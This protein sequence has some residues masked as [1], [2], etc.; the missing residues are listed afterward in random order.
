MPMEPL[1]PEPRDPVADPMAEH[2]QEFARRR[3]RTR[4]LVAGAILLPLLLALALLP[5]IASLPPVRARLLAQ[6]NARL[7]PRLLAVESWRLRWWGPLVFRGVRVTDATVGWEAAA[8]EVTVSRGLLR[9]LPI[10]RLDLGEV[11]VQSPQIALRLPDLTREAGAT[12]AAEPPPPSGK[13][14]PPPPRPR[15]RLPVADLAFR[16]A[17][18]NGRLQAVAADGAEIVLTDLRSAV[19]LSSLAKPLTVGADFQVQSATGHGDVSVAL[20][21]DRPAAALA[22]EPGGLA[23]SLRLHVAGVDLTPLNALA[24]VRLRGWRVGAGQLDT[25]L[26]M[27]LDWPRQV[28]SETEVGVTGLVLQAPDAAAAPM[29]AADVRLAV[30]AVYADGH[31]AVQ[32]GALRSPWVTASADGQFDPAS[33]GGV[34][35]GR[36]QADVRVDLPAAARDFGP[37]LGLQPGV[38][39]DSGR[40]LARVAVAGERS[41]LRLQASLESTNLVLHAAGKRL[42]IEPPPTLNLRMSRAYGQPLEV[43]AFD[44]RASFAQL[45]GAGSY[46]RAQAAGYLDLTALSRDFGKVLGWLPPMVGRIDLKGRLVRNAETVRADVQLA[47]ADVAVALTADRRLVLEQAGLAAA[48]DL[49]LRAGR[50]TPELENLT[51]GFAGSPGTVSGGC[52][53]VSWP[54]GTNAQPWS[55][56]GGAV[57]C[58]LD[59]GRTA[60]LAAPW[61]KL[62]ARTLPTGQLLAG[63]TCE[64]GAGIFK[65]RYQAAVRRV[66]WETSNWKIT[67]P[68]A[69]LSGSAELVPAE[70]RLKL[71]DVEGRA[72]VGRLRIPE[73][74]LTLPKGTGAPVFR[75]KSDGSVDLQ[76]LNAWRKPPREGAK[77]ALGGTVGFEAAAAS[78]TGGTDLTLSIAVTDL[79]LTTPGSRPW[80][81]P[82]A[83]LALDLFQAHDGQSLTFRKLEMR[84]SLLGLE[85]DGAVADLQKQVRA[86]LAGQMALDFG[87]LDRLLRAEGVR[88][89]ALAGRASR[90]FELQA[91][92]AAGPAAVFAYGRGQAAWYIESLTAFGLSAGPAD[93]KAALADGV[94]KLE[95]AP[96]L[97]EGRARLLA[98]L[99]LTAKPWVLTVP[100]ETRVLDKVRLTDEML[101]EVLGYVNPLLRECGTTGGQISLTCSALHLPLDQTLKKATDFSAQLELIDIELE[102]AGVLAEILAMA[103]VSGQ[104][105]KLAHELI[106]VTCTDGRVRPGTQRATIKGYPITFS[107]TVG[108][109]GT[110]AYRVELP[111]TEE[112][113]GQEAWKYLK[114]M[115]VTIPVTGTLYRPAI[116]RNALKSEIRRL[117]GEAAQQAMAERAG[118]LLDKLRERVNK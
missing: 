28:T 19:V 43:E 26:D 20:T 118:E 68:D 92:L 116:D 62:P 31:L 42:A 24:G 37:L 95:Y 77:R 101:R 70:R 115:R 36:I 54:V 82:K 56:R 18:T 93:L 64:G 50:L 10:G 49:P 8:S 112:V 57:Q 108:L 65:T 59:L 90:P 1:A 98:D 13:A 104:K 17:I 94:L 55:V 25:T 23:A 87:Q 66:V 76:A 86:S 12:P 114:G 111:L 14:E 96:P 85:A 15:V 27:R 46:A 79:S 52:A 22:G 105:V 71:A 29:P 3:R 39:V 78:A 53:R 34:P 45:S 69:R 9:V 84:S 106:D 11:A 107:G 117:V 60:R 32:E 47:A 16:L 38:G 100:R 81:E 48:A 67:E 7:A 113:V 63:L 40:L 110:V 35:T 91:P 61:L 88:Y 44:L 73:W 4:W 72:S 75:G 51:W 41:G 83:T 58:D 21:L 80:L 74:T 109:D 2:E 5:Q 6:A 102:P 99:A 89:P 97:N 103:G 30:H 33:S